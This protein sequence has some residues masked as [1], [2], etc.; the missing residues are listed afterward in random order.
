[1]QFGA[2]F[3]LTALDDRSA[4]R[5][6][7]QTL[8]RAGFDFVTTGGHVLSSEAGR[9]PDRPV[10]TYAG[11]FY[12][13]FVLFSYLAAITDHLA[14]RPNILILPL[15]PTAFVAKQAAELSFFS[16]GRFQLGIGI[17]RDAAE[18][19]AMNQDLHTR[20]RRLEEQLTVLRRLWSEPFVTFEGRWHTFDQIGL[21]RLPKAP[22]P[23]WMGTGNDDRIL[24][25]VARLADGWSPQGDPTEPLS[26]LRQHLMD[27]GRDPATFGVTSRVT[28]GP[29]GP[30][31]W[32]EAGCR[33]QSIGITDIM[34]G[35]PPDLAPAQALQRIVEARQALAAELN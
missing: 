9:Y 28:A 8:D 24:R 11:P 32:I 33:L 4:I 34:I 23:I 14:F 5:D 1:M 17:G 3:A 22:I 19:Q 21:N 10:P 26:R 2:A 15:F 31:A 16:D 6:F 13:P 27:A 29:D 20:G 18:Y 35:A 30:S 7:A 25:R 12:D